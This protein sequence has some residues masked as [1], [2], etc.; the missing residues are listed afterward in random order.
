MKKQIR[1]LP[2]LVTGVLA[3]LSQTAA[4]P[5]SFD[6]EGVEKFIGSGWPG[7]SP[8]SAPSKTTSCAPGLS[9]AVCNK[10]RSRTPVHSPIEVQPSTQSC[11]VIW[12]RAGRSIEP[13]EELTYDYNTEGDKTIPCRCRPGCK[14]KL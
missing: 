5:K 12:V 8:R 2:L 4:R 10:S 14:T 11:L 3:A 1:K 6:A 7:S 9:P 13:G